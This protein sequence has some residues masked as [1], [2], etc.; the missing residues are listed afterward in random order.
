MSNSVI[1]Q[2]EIMRTSAGI[3]S[4]TMLALASSVEK[5]NASR[6]KQGR[7]SAFQRSLLN[8]LLPIKANTIAKYI[9][10]SVDLGVL[11]S[12]LVPN[13]P[14][15]GSTNLTG[16]QTQLRQLLHDFC[17]PKGFGF[18]QIQDTIRNRLIN[19][20]AADFP[21]SAPTLRSLYDE[22]RPG[23]NEFKFAQCLEMFDLLNDDFEF[24][25][26]RMAMHQRI[27]WSV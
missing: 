21:I 4:A 25:Q 3:N 12:D 24:R 19:K 7:P 11:T 5:Y 15:M 22:V 18:L 1:R 8:Q 23:I 26:S 9:S 16:F 13:P 20:S 27:F 6:I 17:Q 14:L 2:Y 10:L